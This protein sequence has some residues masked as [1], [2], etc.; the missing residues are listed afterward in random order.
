LKLINF[1]DEEEATFAYDGYCPLS[2]RLIENALKKGHW[3]NINEKI[4]KKLPFDYYY[5]KDFSW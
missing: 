1:D 2:M 4:L 3:N 5:N